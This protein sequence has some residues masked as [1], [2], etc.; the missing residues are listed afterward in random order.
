MTPVFT[1]LAAYLLGAIPF[2]Y[3]LVRLREG[4][5]IRSVGSGNIG[6]TNVLRTK[7]KGLGILTLA[8]DAGK[9]A[10]AVWLARHFAGGSPWSE[11]A[12]ALVIV[13][14]AYPVFIGFR[15]GK[16]VATGAGAF[17]VLFPK[18]LL[19]A[20]VVFVALTAATRYVAVG[21]IAA[22]LSLPIAVWYFTRP[23][24]LAEYQPL[25]LAAAFGA[26]FITCRHHENIRRLLNG[27]EHPLWGA[28]A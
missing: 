20:L 17:A 11:A 2:G 27:T 14:H 23:A 22:A 15:G 24:T 4:S 19:V 13:G 9:G 26:A 1:L 5:D 10:F 16:S 21:S 7:G 25:L 6:A 3:L 12:A 28:G 8:L 18:A